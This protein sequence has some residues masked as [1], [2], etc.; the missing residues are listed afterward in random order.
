MLKISTLESAP[1]AVTLRLEGRVMGAWVVELEVA[2]ERILS[3]GRALRLH[4]AEVAFLDAGGLALLCSLR[5]QGVQLLNCSPFLETQ[6]GMRNPECDA[7]K[8]QASSVD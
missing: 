8:G 5:A 1:P 7:R 4:V 2:C 3:Q 6:L